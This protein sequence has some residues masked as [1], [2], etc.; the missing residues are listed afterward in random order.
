MTPTTKRVYEVVPACQLKEGDLI[1]LDGKVSNASYHARIDR[2]WHDTA[3]IGCQMTFWTNE[4]R[5]M[6]FKTLDE[7][8]IS[9]DVP[10][11]PELDWQTAYDRLEAQAIH[12]QAENDKLTHQL[13]K[14]GLLTSQSKLDEL[15]RVIADIQ[16]LKQGLSDSLEGTR[17]WP[18]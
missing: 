18:F 15:N 4:P 3:R 7:F 16:R 11:E 10:V 5:V 17:E 8:A 12:L 2:V 13:E 6:W 1:S 9:R 14:F